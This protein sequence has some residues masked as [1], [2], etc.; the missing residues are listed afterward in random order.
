M[1]NTTRELRIC[2]FE[3]IGKARMCRRIF[4]RI[5]LKVLSSPSG[6]L[7]TIAK[8]IAVL[9]LI[10]RYLVSRLIGYLIEVPRDLRSQQDKYVLL[11]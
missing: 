1:S 2:H 9:H 3:T 8:I 4:E 5:R 10:G 6:E 7:I 11:P